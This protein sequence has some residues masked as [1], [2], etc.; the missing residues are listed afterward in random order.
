LFFATLLLFSCGL[1]CACAAETP[2]PVGSLPR[3]L[4]ITIE[5]STSGVEFYQPAR[6]GVLD[7]QQ[8]PELRV[9]CLISVFTTRTTTKHHTWET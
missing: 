2:R 7:P 3:A 4:A 9:T 6:P 8:P 1:Q 5:F